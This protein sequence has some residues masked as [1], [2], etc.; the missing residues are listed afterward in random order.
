MLYFNVHS[1][2]SKIDDLRINCSLFS[3]G[4]VCVV[5]TWLDDSIDDSKSF[6]QGYSVYR[7]DRNR[8]G[9]GVLIYDNDMFSSSVL[10]KGSPEFELLV[11]SVHCSVDSSPDFCICLLYTS[12]SPRDATLSRMPSSA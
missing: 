12:P 3:P 9:S 7:L 10:Y 5:E 11:I 4:V 8:H 1:L 6:V 2:L